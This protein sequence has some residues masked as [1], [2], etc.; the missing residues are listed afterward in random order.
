MADGTVDIVISNCVINLSTDKP[1]VVREAFRVLKR[2]GRLALP[3]PRAGHRVPC[4][5]LGTLLREG[6]RSQ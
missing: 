2:G 4:F 3:G 6:C 1:A 5:L